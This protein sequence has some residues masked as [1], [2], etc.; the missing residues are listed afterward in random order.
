MEGTGDNLE[1]H[2]VFCNKGAPRSNREY[3]EHG[4]EQEE[5]KEKWGRRFPKTDRGKNSPDCHLIRPI[6]YG[7]DR[8]AQK[9]NLMSRSIQWLSV[10]ALTIA[11]R[12]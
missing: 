10:Y 11:G 9:S 2:T 5:E 7:I 3:G 1:Q 8:L 6:P 4:E 12:T